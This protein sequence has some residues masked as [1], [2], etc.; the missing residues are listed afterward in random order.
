VEY[1]LAPD[2]VA[3]KSKVTVRFEATGGRSAPSVLGMRI[4]RAD[5]ER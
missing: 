4:V 5:L 3:G 1:P 2:L